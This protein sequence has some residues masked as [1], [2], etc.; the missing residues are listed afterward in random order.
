VVFPLSSA[1]RLVVIT[2]HVCAAVAKR[3]D[4]HDKCGVPV[5]ASSP[6]RVPAEA[7]QQREPDE[8]L[9]RAREREVGEDQPRDELPAVRPHAEH[10]AGRERDARR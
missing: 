1:N 7:I 5:R 3:G 4:K 6:L 10:R 9:A 2:S 8:G